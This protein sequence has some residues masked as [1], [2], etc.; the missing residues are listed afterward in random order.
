MP[1]TSQQYA[2]LADHCYGRNLDGTN[3]NLKSLIGEKVTI[4]GVKYQ[5]LEHV[6]KPSGYQGTI[7]QRVDT[8]E[9][10]V[11]HRGTEFGREAI[12]DGLLADGGMVFGRLNT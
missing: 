6:D 2:N 9:I 1:L 11:A 3:V 7:Y 12:K 5:V 8:R 10:V 4:E